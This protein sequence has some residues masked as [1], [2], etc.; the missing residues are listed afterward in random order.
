[1]SWSSQIGPLRK[2][3][4]VEG[5]FNIL[6]GLRNWRQ[7][8]AY[9]KGNRGLTGAG[10]V[11]VVV[12]GTS[13]LG[14]AGGSFIYVDN[15]IN[16]LRQLLQERF[17]PSDVPG[18]YGF[19]PIMSHP[20]SIVHAWQSF[21]NGGM[22]TNGANATWSGYGFSVY[23]GE[24][25][26]SKGISCRHM[27]SASS[28]A[29]PSQSCAWLYAVGM[30]TNHNKQAS[31][32][33]QILPWKQAQIVYSTNPGD[34]VF[35]WGWGDWNGGVIPYTDGAN[36][37]PDYPTHIDANAYQEDVDC[38]G[39]EAVGL[40]S[41]LA[42]VT[43]KTAATHW[44]Q[45]DQKEANNAIN[46]EGA[47]LYCDDVDQ[48][49]RV[50]NL[51]C[52]SA[53]SSDYNNAVTLA[54]LVR[55]GTGE[56]K[57]RNAKLVVIELGV[58]DCGS[59]ASPVV[60]LATYRANLSTL[61]TSV[62]SWASKPSILLWYPPCQDNA[63]ALARYGDYISAGKGLCEEHGCALLDFWAKTGHSPH[64][65]NGAGGYMFDRGFYSDGVH[66]S[67]KGQDWFAHETFGAVCLGL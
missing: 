13:I 30:Q 44:I 51:A 40:R 56:D 62:K 33:A 41:G 52:G 21:G 55:F 58:N 60:D 12:L 38:D 5:G 54:G 20:P 18:G 35:R 39:A 61:I 48:G 19:L 42:D 23:T 17:N 34:G 28:L 50:H 49:V 16:R 32:A 7:A 67:D 37:Y 3:E 22:R 10:G 46:I 14:G 26:Q 25:G 4:P 29:G 53:H 45:V 2:Q 9:S 47:I 6:D 36:G 43:V 63:N 31:A 65:G 24:A 1:M 15:A 57:S 11:D 64:G 59:G 8:L 27:R 66:Y